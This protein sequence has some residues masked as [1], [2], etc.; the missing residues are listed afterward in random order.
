MIRKVLVVFTPNIVK[1]VCLIRKGCLHQSSLSTADNQLLASGDPAA[2]QPISVAASAA[3]RLRRFAERR[4][5]FGA[6]QQCCHHSMWTR[7]GVEPVERCFF[8]RYPFVGKRAY[9]SVVSV[10]S[11]FFPLP[12]PS[13]AS[14]AFIQLLA[15]WEGAQWEMAMAL[16]A[17]HMRKGKVNACHLDALAW[18]LCVEVNRI[19]A[20]QLIWVSNS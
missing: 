12:S 15:F 2:G 9:V 20:P 18:C 6:C 17:E 3:L 10:V 8:F 11:V 14:F 13:R 7:W 4:E 5:L 19:G 16:L 1:H